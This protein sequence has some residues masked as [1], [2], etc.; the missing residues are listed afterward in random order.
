MKD[1]QDLLSSIPI[2]SFLGRAETAAVDQLFVESTHQKGDIICRQGDEGST[3]HVILDGELDVLAGE[4]VVTI[5]K[6]GDFFGEMALPQGG[7][8]TASVIANRRVKLMTLDR[9]S[10]NGLFMK[11]PKALEYF[12]RVLCR[13]LASTSSGE[14]T[15][16]SSM[17]ITVGSRN[18]SLKGKTL[19]ASALAG[20]L[21]DLTKANV[22]IVRVRASEHP[23]VAIFWNSSPTRNGPT[24]WPVASSAQIQTVSRWWK[25]PGDEVSTLPFTKRRRPTWSPN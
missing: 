10:F 8:R 13:R 1:F 24:T 21:H 19:V 5:L 15:R 7:K 16:G 11:N 14:T 17:V 18:H 9:T 25:F 23:P 22:I 3:F 2:F 6:R 12:A 20:V 4:R